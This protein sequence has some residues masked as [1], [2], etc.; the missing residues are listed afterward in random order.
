MIEPK[1]RPPWAAGR[2][3]PGGICDGGGTVLWESSRRKLEFTQCTISSSRD[4]DRRSGAAPCSLGRNRLHGP[5]AQLGRRIVRDFIY[6]AI[7]PAQ[8]AIEEYVGQQ[9]THPGR[10]ARKKCPRQCI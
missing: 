5:Q 6:T 2:R 9:P 8:P 1:D 4:P 7:A 3:D 10:M